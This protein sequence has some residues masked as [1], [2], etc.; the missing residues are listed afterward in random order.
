MRTPRRLES[1]CFSILL[2][3]ADTDI[4]ALVEIEKN[5]THRFEFFMGLVC[6]EPI[7][8]RTAYRYAKAGGEIAHGLSVYECRLRQP[9]QVRNHLSHHEEEIQANVNAN[10]YFVLTCLKMSGEMSSIRWC[11]YV[12][13]SNGYSLEIAPTTFYLRSLE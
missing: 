3:A 1:D 5:S 12:K 13:V 2:Q 11:I 4:L 7:S 8:A 6:E 9:K 10:L